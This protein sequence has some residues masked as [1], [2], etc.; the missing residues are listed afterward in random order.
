M[1]CVGLVQLVLNNPVMASPAA[2]DLLQACELSLNNGFEGIEGDMCTWYVTP[3]DCDY[4][5]VNDMPKVCL[6]ESVPVETLARAVVAGLRKRTELH[7]E[8][9]DFAAAAILSRVYPCNQ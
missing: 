7:A 5:K 8:N 6:P 1:A 9:A 2:A 3:C 4:G